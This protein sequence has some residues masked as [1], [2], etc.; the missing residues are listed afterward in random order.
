MEDFIYILLGIV[1]IVFS[2][3]KGTQKKKTQQY[4]QDS[5][6]DSETRG[7]LEQ[8][9]EEFLPPTPK[10][11]E[12]EE[13]YYPSFDDDVTSFEHEQN[14]IEFEHEGALEA[15][16]YKFYDGTLEDITTDI[17]SL[18]EMDDLSHILYKND[19]D[20][21]EV[22]HEKIDADWR[23]NFSLKKEIIYQAILDRP[24]Q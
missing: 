8:W 10:P 11:A 17:V 24:Y 19:E 23:E 7:G 12:V 16:S 20:Q 2:V 6:G 22:F 14:N 13:T 5:E 4:E 3:I 18:E 15:K 9:L 21:S 1:W